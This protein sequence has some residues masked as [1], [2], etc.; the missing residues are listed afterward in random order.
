VA[1]AGSLGPALAGRLAILAAIFTTELLAITNWLDT[2]ALLGRHGL[3][4]LVGDWGPSAIRLALAS[5]LAFLI[6][7]E[8]KDTG[9]GWGDLRGEPIAWRLLAGHAAAM[10][11]LVALSAIV[12]GTAADGA[13]SNLEVVAWIATGLAAVALAAC[14]LIPAKIWIARIRAARD[15]LIF[16]PAAG[17]AACLLGSLTS[18]LW[19]PLSR[20]TFALA[21]LLLRPFLDHLV[22]DPAALT[23]GSSKF[24]VSIAPACS[25]YEGIGL[26]LAVTSA[27]LWFLRRQWRFP[28]ALV[29]IPAG[30]AA[31]WILNGVRIASLILIGNAGAERMA[32]GGF[33]SQAGWIAFSLVSLGVCAAARRVSWFN[34]QPATAAPVALRTAPNPLEVYLVPFLAILA[35]GLIARAASADFEWLYG[36]RVAAAAGV[37][38]YFRRSYRD[39]DLRFGAMALGIGAAVFALWVALDRFASLAPAAAPAA[40]VHAP[41]AARTTWIAIRVLGAVITVPIA[42]ELAFRG[43]L[44]RRLAGADF[45]SV[46]LR[47][48]PWMPMVISSLAFGILHGERWLAGAIAG[49]LY[50]LAMSRRGRLGDAIAAHGFTNLLLAVWVL[51]TGNWALW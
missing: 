29:L 48:V 38:W 47:N 28:N 27:W 18:H 30:I 35:A 14:A 4:A 39:L 46:S 20:G 6:L 10:A 5:V 23:L 31:V 33:H 40:F 41:L 45:E 19:K 50:A 24:S 22:A 37:L 13:L 34:V 1:A 32:L 49:M 51:A 15:L 21:S 11:A 2:A 25:G 26:I 42:E 36:L 16:A 12:F 44:L 3:A 9:S 43:F 7:G 17:L 8:S